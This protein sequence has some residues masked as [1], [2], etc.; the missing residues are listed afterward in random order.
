MLCLQFKTVPPPQIYLS[1]SSNFWS[2]RGPIWLQ[3]PNKD[4][5]I[6]YGNA[7]KNYLYTNSVYLPAAVT[8]YCL[9]GCLLDQHFGSSAVTGPFCP[10]GVS[11]TG[12]VYGTS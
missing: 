3:A 9:T 5:K 10:K 11:K 1:I 6:V 8:Q 2:I 7:R 4:K 12:T